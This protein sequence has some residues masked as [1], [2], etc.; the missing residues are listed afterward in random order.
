MSVHASN[1][2][3]VGD[4]SNTPTQTENDKISKG[5]IMSKNETVSM[6]CGIDT[7]YF[8]AQ[9]NDNYE[10]FFEEVMDQI[11]LQQALFERYTYEHKNSAILVKI[12]NRSFHYVNKKEGYHWFKE[13]NGYFRMGLKDRDSKAQLHGIQ[14]QLEGVGIYTLGIKALVDLIFYEV[15]LKVTTGVHPITRIDINCFVQYDFAF[16]DKTM[17]V[18]KKKRYRRIDDGNARENQ[19]IYIGSRPF[20]LRLYDKKAELKKSE[21]KQIMEDYFEAH[22]FMLD[23]PIY[24]VEFE[25]HRQHLRRFNLLELDDVLTHATM[26]FKSAMEDIRL[27][28]M[29][30]ITQKDLKNNSKNRAKSLP[31]WDYIKEHFSIESF[32]QHKESLQRLPQKR[33]IYD[34]PKFVNDAHTLLNKAIISKIDISPQIMSEITENALE[35]NAPKV[36]TIHETPIKKSDRVHVYVKDMEGNLRKRCEITQDQRIIEC[37]KAWSTMS[38]QEIELEIQHLEGEIFFGDEEQKRFHEQKLE[39]AH[40]ELIRRLEG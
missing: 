5:E 33:S 37:V 25:M 23:Q 9:T 14:I 39:L 24:N 27:V 26:L 16:V 1:L 17:F 13:I 40:K 4:S 19:T 7:L 20:M 2:I 31:I 28:D 12:E 18:S 11:Y 32:L 8:F 21:K 22:G 36:K 30:T 35:N 38:T 15:I 10:D 6:M 29:T 3:K 34:M